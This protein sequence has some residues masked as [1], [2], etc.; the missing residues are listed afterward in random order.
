MGPGV[1]P[2]DLYDPGG[3]GDLLYTSGEQFMNNTAFPVVVFGLTGVYETLL[4]DKPECGCI[5]G[6]PVKSCTGNLNKQ[7]QT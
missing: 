1:D 6:L 7:A 3:V 5:S 2:G 4:G